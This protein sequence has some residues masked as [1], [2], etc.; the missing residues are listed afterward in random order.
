[1]SHVGREV[2]V[3]VDERLA[4]GGGEGA[5]ERAAAA[6]SFVAVNVADAVVGGGESV[7]NLWGPIRTAVLGDDHLEGPRREEVGERREGRLDGPLD[8]PRLVVGGEDDADL[9]AGGVAGP[10]H[11]A[12]MVGP[13]SRTFCLGCPTLFG[14]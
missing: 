6:E 9:D 8:G 10:I 1:M 3:E 5:F 11:L 13:C 12:R 14:Q 2:G 4:V 7:R